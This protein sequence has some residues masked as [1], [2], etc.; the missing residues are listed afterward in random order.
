MEEMFDTTVDGFVKV[1]NR[2]A[3]ILVD[4]MMALIKKE[5]F[6]ELFNE[7]WNA[8]KNNSAAKSVVAT[9]LDFF[10]DYSA[11]ISATFYFCTILKLALSTLVSNYI[12][13]FIASQP[14][15]E[16]HEIFSQIEAD[17]QVFQSG[18]SDPKWSE[19]I[20]AKYVEEQIEYITATKSLLE[21]EP[22]FLA[23]Y[24]EGIH[25]NYGARG[26]EFLAK[27]LSLRSD[28]DSKTQKRA[29]QDYLAKY[30]IDAEA[31]VNSGS[32]SPRSMIKAPSGAGKRVKS[33]K[34]G[35]GWFWSRMRASSPGREGD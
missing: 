16:A 35:G 10:L 1:G 32:S 33:P 13:S 11:A 27:A 23:I 25:L 17:A 26:S 28:M 14:N 6:P 3:L 4:Q 31:S 5:I 30:P 34:A 19:Y 21:A 15:L 24:F 20:S 12:E 9:F 8:D 7:T 22:G 18:F 29:I 2:A